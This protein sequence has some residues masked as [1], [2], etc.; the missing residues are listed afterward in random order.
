MEKNNDQKRKAIKKKV[1]GSDTGRFVCK[2]V[3]KF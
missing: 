3:D 1:I 2:E